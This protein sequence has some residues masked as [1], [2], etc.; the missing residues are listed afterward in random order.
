MTLI[1][2]V[3]LTVYLIQ[4]R[5]LEVASITSFYKEYLQGGEIEED[6]FTES[7][8]ATID[9][10]SILCSEV[11]PEDAFVEK[12]T[13][14]GDMIS[15]KMN[16]LKDP[17]MLRL[18][19]EG[20]KKVAEIRCPLVEVEF[21]SELEVDQE[22]DMIKENE[23]APVLA[24][25]KDLAERLKIDVSEIKFGDIESVVFSDSTLGTSAPGENYNQKLTNGYIINLISNE[26]DYRYHADDNRVIFIP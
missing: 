14:E 18:E 8:A 5:D 17:I 2:A 24:A 7:L 20:P 12:I 16:Y 9:S 23:I 11:V 13:Q 3:V 19:G 21:E 6:I 1:M 15:V 26:T 25:K 10:A 4:K 22:T